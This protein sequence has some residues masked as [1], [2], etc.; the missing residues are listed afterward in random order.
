MKK[1]RDFYKSRPFLLSGFNRQLDFR[2]PVLHIILVPHSVNITFTGE[3]VDFIAVVCRILGNISVGF[4]ELAVGAFVINTNRLCRRKGAEFD[5]FIFCSCLYDRLGIS[6][7]DV[8][9]FI[10]TIQIFTKAIV[11]LGTFYAGVE[12]AAF[13]GGAENERSNFTVIF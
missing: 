3:T 11:G 7:Q 2:E 13:R 1:R 8:S 5:S 4:T 12:P 10:L 9:F 6:C